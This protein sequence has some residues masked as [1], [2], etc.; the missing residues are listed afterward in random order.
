MYGSSE[1]ANEIVVVAVQLL[2]RVRLIVT[3][4]TE[5]HEASLVAQQ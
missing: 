1:R 3:P 5:V 2:S 4:L